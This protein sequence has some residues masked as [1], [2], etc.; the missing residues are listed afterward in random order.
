MK[1]HQAMLDAIAAD[2][3]ATAEYTG[4]PTLDP[5]VIAAMAKV[6]RHEFVPELESDYAYANEA[7]PIGYGQTISQPFIVALMTDL[8]SVR[9]DHKILEIGTG[10]GYQAAVLANLATEVYSVEVVPELA[11]EAAR[12]LARLGY[13][14]VSVRS[15][16][17][18]LGWPERAPFD[19]IIVTACAS[20]IPSAL[21]RQLRV[22]G[23]LVMPVGVAHRQDLT[24]VEK[25]AD[26]EITQRVVLPVAFVPLVSANEGLP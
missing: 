18:N 15:G 14:S 1:R 23:R 12:R 21:L 6:P 13:G 5:R 17:G 25:S 16:D 11:E 3:A 7:L 22:G 10:S 20:R 19:G 8:I 24:L 26:G 4:I 9:P 2:A